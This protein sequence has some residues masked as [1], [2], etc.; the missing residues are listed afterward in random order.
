[1][2]HVLKCLMTLS[3]RYRKHQAGTE[4]IRQFQNLNNF[5]A[6]NNQVLSKDKK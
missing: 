4:N 1:M 2:V 3:G 6:Q 5:S